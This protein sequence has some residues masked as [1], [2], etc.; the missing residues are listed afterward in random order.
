MALITGLHLKRNAVCL[1][2]Q[3][4]EFGQ[5]DSISSAV[6]LQKKEIVNLKVVMESISKDVSESVSQI[7]FVIGGLKSIENS[8]SI[9]ADSPTE[10]FLS[11]LS[12]LLT[13][14]DNL[15]QG[16][17]KLSLIVDA[18]Y[19]KINDSHEIVTEKINGN[20][21]IQCKCATMNQLPEWKTLG[22]DLN[23]IVEAIGIGAINEVKIISL[24]ESTIEKQRQILNH[25]NRQL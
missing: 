11:E 21:P 4:G 13:S 17:E 25:L 3:S 18:M 20:F 2:V 19:V 23:K 9:L 14:I 15:N 8:V 6:N 12:L 5:I 24:L 7:E 1:Q 10:D 22:R 16:Q